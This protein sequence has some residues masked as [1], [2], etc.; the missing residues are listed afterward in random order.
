MRRIFGGAPPSSTRREGEL[1]RLVG[2]RAVRR[3][4][5]SA[6]GSLLHANQQERRG[7]AQICGALVPQAVEALA[8]F[9]L[10]GI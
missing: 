4:R 6:S 8:F 9:R 1:H 5:R 10:K 3:V 7:F 2:F